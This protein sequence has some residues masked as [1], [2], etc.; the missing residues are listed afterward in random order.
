VDFGGYFSERSKTSS[1]YMVK[2]VGYSSLDHPKVTH[3]QL[4]NREIVC[5]T[6]CCIRLQHYSAGPNVVKT[7]SYKIGNKKSKIKVVNSIQ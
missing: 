5:D 2:K 4:R 3:P 6:V 1:R 7:K